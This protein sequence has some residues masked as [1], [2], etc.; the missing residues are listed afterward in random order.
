MKVER[1]SIVRSPDSPRHVRLVAGISYLDGARE[2]YWF[3]VEEEFEHLLS[4]VG[5]PWLAC[6]LPLAMVSGEPLELRHPVDPLLYESAQHLMHIWKLWHPDLKVVPVDA[7]VYQGPV[8]SEGKAAAFFSGGVDSF[9]TALRHREGVV[10]SAIHL[11]DLLFVRGADIFIA[12]RDTFSRVHA[13]LA[14]AA[15]QLGMRL[16]VVATNLRDT[17]WGERTNWGKLSNGAALA[18]AA[19]VLEKRY[20]LVMIASSLT[21]RYMTPWG[22]HPLTDPLF[23]TAGLRVFY[24]GAFMSRAGKVKE[25]IQSEVAMRYLR[26]CYRSDEGDN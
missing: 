7:P 8:H 14:E 5:N 26:V 23:S 4:P 24:D 12:K 18:A 17:R 19:L 3:E 21:Y 9:F 10:G 25:L 13:A 11:D 2:E 20:R 22:S 16:V 1:V 15:A 6:L